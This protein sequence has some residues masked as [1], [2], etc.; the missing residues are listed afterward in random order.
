MAMALRQDISLRMSLGSAHNL[1]SWTLGK[2]GKIHTYTLHMALKLDKLPSTSI[3]LFHG[4]GAAT[5]AAGTGE[6]GGKAAKTAD[7]GAAESSGKGQGGVTKGGGGDSALECVHVYK[8]G[9]VGALGQVGTAATALKA[10]RWAWVTV[11]RKEGELRTYVNGRLCAVVALEPVKVN[12]SAGGDEEGKGKDKKAPKKGEGKTR[13]NDA[14]AIDP[15]DFA[16]F[17]PRVSDDA[18]GDLPGSKTDPSAPEFLGLDAELEGIL[19]VKYVSLVCEDLDEDKIR[20]AIHELRATDV[21]M[22]AKDE[23]QEEK[24]EHLML[25]KLYAKP[26]PMWLHPCFSGLFGDPFVEG[27]GL[28]FGGVFTT[29]QVF[30]LVLSK[31][32]KHEGVRMGKGGGGA[33]KY[34]HSLQHSQWQVLNSIALGF[35]ESVKVAQNFQKASENSQQHRQLM[36]VIMSKLRDLQSGE[37]LLVPHAISGNPILFVIEKTGD[38]T[39]TFTVVN[40]NPEILRY[41]PASGQPPKIKYQTCLVL[42]NVAM[43]KIEDEAFWGIAYW[44]AMTGNQPTFTM[45]PMDVLYKILLPFLQGKSWEEI[46]HDQTR[47]S[48]AAGEPGAHMRSPQR[49]E[50]GHLRCLIEA[51]QHL[52]RQRGVEAAKRKEVSLMLRLEMLELVMHDLMFV[53]QLSSPERTLLHLACRQV[54]YSTSKLGQM[55]NGDNSDVLSLKQVTAITTMIDTLRDVMARLPCGDSSVDVAPPPLVLCEED[56]DKLHPSLNTLLGSTLVDRPDSGGDFYAVLGVSQDADEDDIAKAY[57]KAALRHH[58]DKNPNDLEGAEARFKNVQEA[59]EG[60]K[61]GRTGK[62]ATIDCQEALAEA[63]VVGIY[64]TA[65]WCGPCR[66]ATPVLAETYKQLRKKH[67]KAF[68][69]VC[70][71]HD[72]SEAAFQRYFQKMPWLALPFHTMQKT[73]LGDLFQV[74]GIPTLILLNSNGKVISRDG[75]RLLSRHPKAFPWNVKTPDQVPHQHALFDRILRHGDVDAG[76]QKQLRSYAPVDYLQQPAQVTCIDAAIAALRYCDRLCTRV[77][78]QSHCV[79]NGHFHNIALIQY[80]FTQLLPLPKAAGNAA[81]SN[82]IWLSSPLLY[83]QQLDLMLLLQRIMEH[84]VAAAFSVDHT[85]AMDGVRMVV[86][87]CIAAVA[88]AVMHKVATDIPSEVCIHLAGGVRGEVAAAGDAAKDKKNGKNGKA[89]GDKGAV[90]VRVEARKGFGLSAGELAQQSAVIEVFAPEV[91]TARTAVLD[92]FAA[93][94]VH[95]ILAWEKGEKF[96]RTTE[97]FLKQV[98]SDLAFPMGELLTPSLL[99]DDKG[100]LIKNYPE[101]R[102]YR[103][104]SFYFKFF[105]NPHL[106]AVQEFQRRDEG[107]AQR[108]VALYFIYRYEP[109]KGP[110]QNFVVRSFGDDDLQRV[111]CRPRVKKGEMPPTHRFPSLADPSFYSKPYFLESESDVLH[112]WDL[113]DFGSLEVGQAR[114][115]GQQDSEMLLSFLT[116]PY[117]RIPLVVTFFSSDDRIHSLQSDQ[118]QHILD[119]T[120]FEPSNHLAAEHSNLVPTDVPSSAP[121][122]LA[123]AHGLL[124]N[125]LCCSPEVVVSGI[126]N[127]F[128]Q[129]MDLDTGSVK[130]STA[131]II[132]YLVRLASR[133]D[134]AMSFLI[135]CAQGTHDTKRGEDAKFRQLNPSAETLQYLVGAQ[136]NLREILHKEATGIL[137]AWQQKL[138]RECEGKVDDD[139]LDYHTE[140]LC[141]IYAHLLITT[142][143]LALDELDRQSVGTQVMCS[144]FLSTRHRWNTGGPDSNEC[145]IPENELFETMHMMRRKVVQWLRERASQKDLD[146]IMEAAV[147]AAANTAVLKSTE[148]LN[149]WGFIA[150]KRSTGR[151]AMHSR[152]D[153][154]AEQDAEKT[155]PSKTAAGSQS[156]DATAIP[157]MKDKDLTMEIDVQ[158]MQLTLK[159][160]HPSNLPH[161]IAESEDVLAIFGQVTMQACVVEETTKRKCYRL[162]GRSH[163][164]Q[165]WVEDTRLPPLDHFREY[166]PN[167]L[168]PQEKSWIPGI[169]GPVQEAYLMF[170]M[171]LEVYLPEDALPHDAQVAYMIGK[172]PKQTGVWKEIFVYRERR[173]VEIY[174]IESYGHRFYRSLEYSSDTRFCLQAKQPDFNHRNYPKPSWEKYGAGHP[175]ADSTPDSAR[176][177]K[178]VTRDWTVK[179]NLSFGTE[180]YI[181]ARLLSGVLPETLLETHRFWQDEEDQLRGYPIVDENDAGKEDEAESGTSKGE[182]MMIF[183]NLAAGGHVATHGLHWASMRA[184]PDINLPPGRAVVLRLKMSRLEQEHTIV[185]SALRRLEDFVKSEDLLAGPFVVNFQLC[186]GLSQLLRRVGMEK[187]EEGIVGIGA[188]V[189]HGLRTKRKRFRVSEF[190]LPQIMDIL[191]Q[192]L[193]PEGRDA[194]AGSGSSAPLEQGLQRG[195]GGEQQVGA[196]EE[197]EAVLLDLKNAPAGSYLASLVDVMVRLDNLSHILAWAA[198][199]LAARKEGESGMSAVAPEEFR[200]LEP[201]AVCQ[202]DISYVLLPRLKLSF[203]V[204][205]VDG[206]TRLYSLDHSDF[207][208]TNTRTDTAVELLQ[209]IPHS[210]LLSNANG[211]LQV[212]VPSFPPARPTIAARPFSTELVLIREDKKW[213][214]CLDQPYFMFPVHI[215][216]SFLYS[217]TLASALYLL[218]LRFLNRDYQKVAQLVDTISSDVELTEEENQTLQFLASDK[219]SVDLHPDAHACRLK[220]SLVLLDSPVSVPWDLTTEMQRYIRKLTHV[221]AGCRLSHDEELMLLK[222]CVCDSADNKFNPKIHTVFGVTINKNRRSQLRAKAAG[223][224]QCSIEVPPMP[225]GR[226]WMY[227]WDDTGLD[228]SA[229][230]LDALVENNNFSA[231]YRY[232]RAM[233]GVESMMEMFSNLLQC[234]KS[235]N[236]KAAFALGNGFFIFLYDLFSGRTTAKLFTENCSASFATMCLSILPDVHRSLGDAEGGRNDKDRSVLSSLLLTLARK[237]GLGEFLPQMSAQLDTKASTKG[238]RGTGGGDREVSEDVKVLLRS[239]LQDLQHIANADEGNMKRMLS[240][241]VDAETKKRMFG[242][243]GGFGGGGGGYSA[244]FSGGFGGKGMGF[245]GYGYGQTFSQL[246]EIAKETEQRLETELGNMVDWPEL[247]NLVGQWHERAAVLPTVS[248]ISTFRLS[249]S[250]VNQRWVLPRVS[251]H[252]CDSR[253]L[254]PVDESIV[255]NARHLLITKEQLEAFANAPLSVLGLQD[256]VVQV[257]KD[258]AKVEEELGFDVQAHPDAQSKVAQDMHARLVRDMKEYAD[259]QNASLVTLC[260]FLQAP[261]AILAGDA[262]ALSEASTRL[263]ELIRRLEA[264]READMSYVLEALPLVVKVVNAVPIDALAPDEERRRRLFVLR[265][266]AGLECKMSLELLFCSVISS[267]SAEDLKTLNPFMPNA[268]HV[269]N[270]VVASIL[271]ASRVGQVNRSLIEAKELQA[272]LKTLQARLSQRGGED[273]DDAKMRETVSRLAHKADTLANILN[274]KRYYMR[275]E[276]QGRVYDPRFLLFEFT[277]NLV[278]RKAQIELVHEFLDNVR[279][280]KPMVKQMLMG[281]GKTTVVGP[282]LTL[283]LADGDSLVV[284]M[285]PP[286]LLDQTKLT[287]RATFSSIIKKQ[288][289]ILNFDRGSKMTWST[290]DKLQTAVRNRGVVLATATAVKSIQLKLIEELDILRDSRRKHHPQMEHHVRALVR[291]MQMFSSGVLIMDE[292][293]LLLHPLKSELNFPIGAKHPLDFTPERWDLAIH[294]IDAVFYVERKSISVGFQQSSRAHT[295]LRQ[296]ESVITLGYSLRALQKSPHLVLLNEEWYKSHMLPVMAN[297]CHLWLEANNC[298]GLSSAEILAYITR[299]ASVLGVPLADGGGELDAAKPDETSIQALFGGGADTKEDT[300]EAALHKLY[301]KAMCK[302]DAKAFKML[303]CATDWLHIFLPHCLAKIDRVSFGLLSQSEYEE[304]TRVEP[305]MPRSRFKLSIPFVGKDVP[306]RASEFAHPDIIIGL[307]ILAYRYEGLREVDFEQDVMGLLRAS[308]EK[309]IG[310]FRQRKSAILHQTWVEAAGGVI[311]GKLKETNKDKENVDNVSP[312]EAAADDKVMVPLWLLKASNDE[313]MAGLFAL[314]KRHPATIHWYLEQ[315]IFPTFMQHQTVK[316]SSSGTDVGGEIVFQRRIGF[317]GTPS[318]LLPISLGQCGYERGADGKMIHTLTDPAVTSTMDTPMGWTVP[319]LLDQIIS[320]EPHFNALI[321]TGALI[322]GMSNLE[323][324]QYIA[325]RSA[326]C[327]GVV[328]LDS[329]DEKRIYVKATR[330]VVKLAQCGIKKEKRFA[331]YDQIHTTG[332]D[333]QHMLSA[334]AV[335]TLGKDM[336]FRDF[337]QGAFRMRGIGKGQQVCVLIIPE[338]QELMNRQLKKTALPSLTADAGGGAPDV[339]A[340]LRDISAWLVLNAMRTERVQFDQLCTQNICNVWRKNAWDQLVAGHAHF[341]VKP[342]EAGTYILDLLGEAF[343]SAKGNVSRATALEDKYVAILLGSYS[344]CSS[345][346]EAVKSALM[347]VGNELAVVWISDDDDEGRFN[348]ALQAV[349]MLAVPHSHKQRMRKILT[350]FGHTPGEGLDGK[351]VLVDRDGRMISRQGK[352]LF[353]IAEMSRKINEMGEDES[354][355]INEKKAVTHYGKIVRRERIALDAAQVCMRAESCTQ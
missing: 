152:R 325:H 197:A 339:A 101:F 148:N 81:A 83:A 226:P 141:N 65:S 338:V 82:C 183:V 109:G 113:P 143:N 151:F 45:Q 123:T 31:L 105:T 167:E 43:K 112:M 252:S 136:R 332:M 272:E 228:M 279:A 146:I 323:V 12:E 292:V 273:N 135:Q 166:Y 316:I 97:K 246:E 3:K 237:P 118:L 108:H 214:K 200:P 274:T 185:S 169:F 41:H 18:A 239:V 277:W 225:K 13:A 32:L 106:E 157:T 5:E 158:L 275:K 21:F 129:G 286:A 17:L 317:S 223:K 16:L 19:H 34:P 236:H 284:Q 300:K 92:Y 138:M 217:T 80:T 159:A 111:G 234:E 85:R 269:L 268:D 114:A 37:V 344:S 351:L 131:K 133:L 208:I 193:D 260:R 172:Q 76:P 318:D 160:S 224:D 47:L 304:L 206:V 7:A 281:G 39:A 328:F 70:V 222:H 218:L 24:W 177:S 91:N 340:R 195:Q 161:N 93:Q 354:A 62:L 227:E 56:G 301:E 262:S 125:E 28:E 345:V 110:Y 22:D 210:L 174:R 87:A 192:N 163:D 145:Q 116:V 11:T 86:P 51:F 127:L 63:E 49:S 238:K 232:Q 121:H 38:E 50:T 104:I 295:I 194:K 134:N 88:D 2:D 189:V 263:D 20:E 187:F 4:R 23:A 90:S 100:L 6:K 165:S 155:T 78:V 71:S 33:E 89:K 326:W 196:D 128:R 15:V 126:L 168:F 329:R 283:M 67:G 305:H 57:K 337:A 248:A 130:S 327:D 30:N 350:F 306:S 244:G 186:K 320:S 188:D 264:Q 280:G 55:R 59:Y 120:L 60:L 154:S 257:A 69:I 182:S 233:D 258:G 26:P 287:L 266:M 184:S 54:S 173:A 247:R 298:V 204:R 95:T 322:T 254:S 102:C 180:T 103:D 115:L 261:Q 309:E 311:K 149:R 36:S 117:M 276:E 259:Q 61:E 355:Y 221:S 72:Q 175:Y 265:Q 190:M 240:R 321:D 94:D 308:F 171:P 139:L 140:L 77:F 201:R 352:L 271:H 153:G 164:I 215:S 319:G 249:L 216:L 303:N 209:G 191:V 231:S 179:G 40:T 53:Q 162:V 132:L 29:L 335:L 1:Y 25:H 250:D 334:K 181:P 98:S 312:E 348:Y 297:W 124:L 205:T 270:L 73:V 156:S 122:L 242:F 251:D 349:P 341:K 198:L 241:R 288:V 79:K 147:E 14:F 64:F 150:G 35:T 84:F 27:T 314:L 333:I 346:L 219:N 10:E 313:Q 296:L 107:W 199:P 282:L 220:I 9:G 278:L 178:V 235:P 229:A 336:V 52:M 302:L 68:E 289:F 342:E 99:S 324:A 44:V 42:E 347:N 212:L 230:G 243:G 58:P 170:P 207:Y 307:T 213:R 331:F 144:I 330:R 310:P 285:M 8:N 245:G 291:V 353:E 253:T 119:A 176:A 293:D 315:I 142:R 255:G 203:C 290:V 299:D 75:L 267:K 74:E 137:E 211:E 343:V 46:H 96:E 256:W 48:A 202:S 66:Q 294:L